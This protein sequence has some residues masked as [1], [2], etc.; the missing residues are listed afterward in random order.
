MQHLR[1]KHQK[2]VH[3]LTIQK[4]IQTSRD[5]PVSLIKVLINR[6]VDSSEAARE[7]FKPSLN[8]LHSPFLM[9]GMEEAVRRILQAE[10]NGQKILIYGDYDVDGT[11]SVALMCSFFKH[12]SVEFDFYIPDRY[13]EGYGV[14]QQGVEWA[15][16][17]NFSL[18]IALD[19][20]VKAHQPI[21]WAKK[22]GVDF[23]VCDHHTPAATLPNAVAVLDPKREDC[24]YPYKELSGCGIGFKLCQAIARKKQWEDEKWRNLL[25]LV[26]I[27]IACDIVPIT[28]ENRILCSFGLEQINSEP[29]P[30]V[31]VLFAQ[32]EGIL[33]VSD[34]VFTAGPR[35]N[36]AGRIKHGKH[37]VELL[38]STEETAK[39]FGDEIEDHNKNRKELDKD[40]TA[41]ALALI[42]GN[43]QLKKAKSTVVFSESWH[44][45][46]IGI[47]ASRLIEKYYRPTVV[48][49]EFEGKIS[50][51][52]RSVKG[53]DVYQALEQCKDELIQFGGHKYAAGLTIEKS[54]IPSFTEKFEE[55]VAKSILPEQ[56][57]PTLE[58]D[59]IIELHEINGKFVQRLNRMEP[60]G[61]GNR[62]PVFETRQVTVEGSLR[63]IGA[64]KTHAKFKVTD[65]NH[66][67]DAIAFNQAHFFENWQE[68]ELFTIAY[69]IEQNYWRGNVTTQLNIR[70]I[71]FT[72]GQ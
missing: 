32:K 48:L 54:K 52:V 8:H 17:E 30:G 58:I 16:K 29:R 65:G 44:K 55:T 60:F 66:S 25:D 34:L 49:T 43:Q 9:K 3:P 47:V 51:S 36:A 37:A 20:G 39:M 12:L 1:W 57:V 5:W 31:K 7:F 46:V 2:E 10:A 22:N 38:L 59:G 19:C 53:F 42:E 21:E 50:G 15:A 68:G 33:K 24:L 11:T 28:G 40:I 27:S 71:K 4:L 41:D 6:G 63:M 45:G 35:I 67:I 18:I 56:M 23:I 70:D 64:D 72:D 61:P 14:S 62:T 13:T 69:S 26:A